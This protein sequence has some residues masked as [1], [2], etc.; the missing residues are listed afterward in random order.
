MTDNQSL[1]L[2]EL[3]RI[4]AA[5]VSF[6]FEQHV[7]SW[8]IKFLLADVQIH[9]VDD[10]KCKHLHVISSCTLP[11]DT[12]YIITA[13]LMTHACSLARRGLYGKFVFQS[14]H[15]NEMSVKKCSGPPS[16]TQNISG[17]RFQWQIIKNLG[18]K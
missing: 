4:L 11:G 10:V 5:S 1:F 2:L 7:L 8:L 3:S 15:G 18:L 14:E 12:S 13:I 9:T 16:K 6:Q 17:D